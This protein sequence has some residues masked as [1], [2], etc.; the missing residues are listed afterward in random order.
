MNI[1]IRFDYLSGIRAADVVDDPD[2][3]GFVMVKNARAHLR[4]CV[5]PFDDYDDSK[6]QE[7]AIGENAELV[8]S[9]PNELTVKQTFRVHKK[10]L[11]VNERLVYQ[12]GE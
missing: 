8:I 12:G 10:T 2:C 1:F 6:E 4:V 7:V 5:A 11:T 9:I 3:P